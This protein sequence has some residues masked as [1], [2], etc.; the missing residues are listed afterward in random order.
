MDSSVA[1]LDTKLLKCFLAAH[2]ETGG[3]RVFRL[4]V[5]DS[6]DCMRAARKSCFLPGGRIVRAGLSTCR[7]A[8]PKMH[9]LCPSA[10]WNTRQVT[11]VHN[12]ASGPGE[13]LSQ[14]LQIESNMCH[15]AT[16]GGLCLEP[17]NVKHVC[18]WHFSWFWMRLFVFNTA[19]LKGHIFW[20]NVSH[21]KAFQRLNLGIGFFGGSGGGKE[22]WKEILVR[23]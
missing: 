14:C 23:D 7:V 2:N 13:L 22:V 9:K 15:S 8:E 16:P 1:S 10:G 18:F 5:P 21:Y 20:W 11:L 3:W 12:R 17:R 4:L 19:A 6:S